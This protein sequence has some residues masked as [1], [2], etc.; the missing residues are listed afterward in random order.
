MVGSWCICPGRGSHCLLWRADFVK[1]LLC[2][3]VA[4]ILN[5]K[6]AGAWRSAGLVL[7]PVSKRILHIHLKLHTGFVTFVA[8][9]AITN[10]LR[11]E[12]ESVEFY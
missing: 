7:D 10:E 2:C 12:E 9:Y 3:G 1:H 6:A 5:E 8:V 11:N 4:I